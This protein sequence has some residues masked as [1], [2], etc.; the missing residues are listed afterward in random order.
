M[1]IIALFTIA[2]IW[3]QP[4][5]PSTG[6]DKENVISHSMKYYL[7]IKKEENPAVCDNMDE[8][9]GHCTK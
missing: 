9:G 3:E 4:K 7:A 6:L 5:C 2:K 8:S 1:F